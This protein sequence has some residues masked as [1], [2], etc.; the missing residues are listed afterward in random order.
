MLLFLLCQVYFSKDD[1]VTLSKL[2]ND[3][4][5]VLIYSAIKVSKT[6]SDKEFSHSIRVH[7]T[8]NLYFFKINLLEVL[9]Y[10]T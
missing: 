2:T 3:T 1:S 9:L 10:F 4:D 7:L 6:K 5:L 8:I